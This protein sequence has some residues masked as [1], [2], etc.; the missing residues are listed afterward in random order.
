MVSSRRARLLS[1]PSTVSVS[2]S[3]GLFGAWV[4]AERIRLKS[5]TGFCWVCSKSL[6]RVSL[7]ASTVKSL[8]SSA[9]RLV[10]SNSLTVSLSSFPSCLWSVIRLM[11]I[12]R[13]RKKKSVS[14]GSSAK[15]FRRSCTRL[16][17]FFCTRHRNL[18]RFQARTEQLFRIDRPRKAGGCCVR[19]S[20]AAVFRRSVPR[21]AGRGQG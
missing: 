2:A 1:F 20:K 21:S 3:P 9:S 5:T 6:L 14:S 19:S 12:G 8:L 13:S 7:K 4:V 18:W 10:S 15:N 16:R 11:L 17:T